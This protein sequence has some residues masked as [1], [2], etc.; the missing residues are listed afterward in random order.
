MLHVM[1]PVAVDVYVLLPE[2]WGLCAPCERL[3]ESAQGGPVLQAHSRDDLPADWQ[4]TYDRLAQMLRDFRERYG[5]RIQIRLV[6]PRSPQGLV[7]GLRHGIRQ[8]PTFV[9]GGRESVAG[10]NPERLEQALRAATVDLEA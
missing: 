10:F 8:Y 5:D 6:D 9:I 1:K 7:N 4:S 2:A 3:L